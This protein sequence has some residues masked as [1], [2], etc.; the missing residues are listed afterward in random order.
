MPVLISLLRGVNVGGHNKIKMDALRALYESLKLRDPQTYV[1][2]GNVVFRSAI[3]DTGEVGARI[4]EGI[5][6]R[7]GLSVGVVMRTGK[8]LIDVTRK[9][10]FLGGRA[11]PSSLHVTFLADV[12]DP[13]AALRIDPLACAPDELVVLDR[14]IYLRCPQGYGKTKLTN[15]LFERQLGVVATT[16]NWRTVTKLAELTS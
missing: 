8:D 14:E 13:S 7:L 10:P 16:R 4:E 1:Q 5:A 2:S 12:P 9:N 6:E 3:E 15:A 11:D